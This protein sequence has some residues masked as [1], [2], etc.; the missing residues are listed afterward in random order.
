MAGKMIDME[1]YARRAHFEYFKTLA[2]P[3]VGVT[4]DTDVTELAAFCKARGYSFYLMFLHAAALAADQIPE[5]RQR[6]HHGGI[7]EYEVCPTSHVELLENGTYCYCTLHH[8]MELENYI[9]S[10]EDARERC[11]KNGTIEE[12][13]DVES[14][15]FISSLPW[16]H[17]SAVIQPVA[18]GEDS[19][20]RITW[21]KYEKDSQG[22]LMLP[23]TL[24]VHH[25]LADGV[26]IAA[27]YR[28]LE[29]QIRQLIVP[30]LIQ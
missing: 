20:P 7:I 6:I 26:H 4:V 5:L 25:A 19:N 3:Y 30:D 27:F 9:R 24:L 10:A 22:R 8:H 29:N 13:E 21:G 17:Y 2:F 18:G 12:D 14:M 1:R 23:V 16:I 15:Y 28:N 11:R